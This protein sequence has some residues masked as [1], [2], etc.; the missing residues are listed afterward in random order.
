LSRAAGDADRAAALDL[1]DLADDRADRT[2]RAGN[3]DRVSR[4]RLADVEQ[5]EVRGHA[6]H[7]ERSEVDR[8]RC[9]A[10]IDPT[11][12]LPSLSEYSCT[13]VQPVT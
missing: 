9:D 2:R 8:Q 4:L 1:R 5:A 6:R 10:R 11:S 3:D 12:P 7:A 13:P